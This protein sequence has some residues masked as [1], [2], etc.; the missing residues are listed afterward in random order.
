MEYLKDLFTFNRSERRGIWLL[1]V[2]IVITFAGGRLLK[3]L[4]DN[5]TARMHVV[6]LLADTTF[7]P[8]KYQHQQKKYSEK[9]W[10]GKRSDSLFYFDPN[11]NSIQQW[12]HLG[13]TE[14]QAMVITGYVSRGGRFRKPEDLERSFV[15]TPQFFQK[16]RP[17]IRIAPMADAAPFENS[18]TS[19]PKVNSKSRICM[20]QADTAEWRTLRGIG[21]GYAAR[22]VKYR[23]A[24]GGFH[25]VLQLTEVYGLSEETVE[26]NRDRIVIHELNLRKIQVNSATE[27]ELVKHPYISARLAYCM[28]AARKAGRIKDGDDLQRRL[29]EGVELNPKLMPYLQY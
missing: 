18:I 17:Y 5:E 4:P 13:L 26:M 8:P 11:T 3:W 6:H 2:L 1:L 7:H 28:V 20:N 21:T 29:P 12:Q 16:V 27:K 10:G 9:Q 23:D 25:D 15:I 24:L 19:I 22:I 14:K